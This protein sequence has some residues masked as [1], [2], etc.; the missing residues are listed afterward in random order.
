[1]ELWDWSLTTVTDTDMKAR[2]RGVQAHM[3][4]FE[5]FFGLSLAELLLR[6]ADNLSRTLQSKDLS[7]AESKS[8]AHKTVLT[9]QGMRS[10]QCFDLF[11]EKV[12]MKAEQRSVETPLLPRRRKVPS[13][14]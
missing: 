1:M 10:D 9:L 11:W 5:F 6:N 4:K 12:V 2:I 14:F 3:Q 7:A 13:R 8:I